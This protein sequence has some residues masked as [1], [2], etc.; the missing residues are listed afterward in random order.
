MN[1]KTVGQLK[2][3]LAKVPDT[4]TLMFVADGYEA[5]IK[6]VFVS[7]TNPIVYFLEFENER[8]WRK[9]GCVEAAQVE[10]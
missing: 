2:K 6:C 9:K 8:P 7:R 4:H 3:L 10:S 1:L 5:D